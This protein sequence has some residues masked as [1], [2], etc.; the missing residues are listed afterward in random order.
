MELLYPLLFKYPYFVQSSYTFSQEF[1]L[2]QSLCFSAAN[3]NV[4]K[5]N[6][7]S[8]FEYRFWVII[9]TVERASRQ[10]FTYIKSITETLKK[11]ENYSKLTIKTLERLSTLFIFNS[12]HN[13][14]LFIVSCCWLWTSKCLLGPTLSIYKLWSNVLLQLLTDVQKS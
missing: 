14:L 5:Y 8:D 11:C 4:V 7:C 2:F 10:T 12:G 9:F 3:L 1:T 6:V 13:S